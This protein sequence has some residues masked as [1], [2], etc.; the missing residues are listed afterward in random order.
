MLAGTGHLGTLDAQ[1][2]L[3]KV[4]LLKYIFCFSSIQAV[5]LRAQREVYKLGAIHNLTT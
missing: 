3:Q 2:S 5:A 4:I 1:S